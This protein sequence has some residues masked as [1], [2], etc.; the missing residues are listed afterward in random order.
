MKVLVAIDG[1]ETSGKVLAAIGGWAASAA[2][3][4]HVL[5]VIHPK[6][7]HATL[8]SR[9]FSHS[10]TPQ[11]TPAGSILRAEEP[12]S[13]A[14]EDRTQA[15]ERAGQ[16][17][18]ARLRELAAR[19]MPG[20]QTKLHVE[21]SDKTADEIVNQASR[22]G[23]GLIAMGSHGRSGVARAILG[24]VAEQVVRSSPVP[25]LIVG[26]AMQ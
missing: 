11:G 19:H 16:E 15:L 22:L 13:V 24:S 20:L 18:L 6:D 17:M 25:V 23:A 26:P 12:P 14:A 4:V 1:G 3:D 21:W 2:A 10:L 7:V 8:A 9:G 5:S